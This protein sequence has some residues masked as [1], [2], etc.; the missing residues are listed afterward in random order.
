M[1]NYG[2]PANRS[3]SAAVWQ[4]SKRSQQKNKT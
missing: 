3:L 1:E 2:F 4:G